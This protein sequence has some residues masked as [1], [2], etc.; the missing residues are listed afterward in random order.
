MQIPDDSRFLKRETVAQDVFC[1]LAVFQLYNSKIIAISQL[2]YSYII[3]IS[4]LTIFFLV[5]L[6]RPPPETNSG[7]PTGFSHCNSA[8]FH[9][10][11]SRNDFFSFFATQDF[12]GIQISLPWNSPQKFSL[13]LNKIRKNSKVFPV[14]S[15]LQDH[16]SRWLYLKTIFM[17]YL[18]WG[19][20]EK[21]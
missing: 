14:V 8:L 4:Q 7:V 20:R 17:A 2:Y 19:I 15:I 18:K 13:Y 12:K 11:G 9:S 3:A 5:I 16:R 1:I 21:K 10:F 6:H